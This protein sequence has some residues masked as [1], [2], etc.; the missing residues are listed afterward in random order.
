VSPTPS[1]LLSLGTTAP[2]FD[3]PDTTGRRV[4]RDGLADRAALLVMFI[5]NH[6]PYVKHVAD[7]LARI[8]REYQDRGVGIVAISSNDVAQYPEDGPDAMAE[9]AAAHGFI[10]PYLYDETQAVA[11]AYGAACTPDPFLFDAARQLVYRGQLD[12][13]RPANDVPVD[14]RDLRAAL[15]ATLAG[16][17]VAE[18]QLPSVGC[19]IKWK[20]GHG[21]AFAA[22]GLG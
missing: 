4:S 7:E 14:A 12:G 9:F 17:S 16:G 2:D 20:P 5:C 18:R 8:G 13:A 1:I 15:E 19:S 22:V 11:E 10:F 21:P 6:C 3:L